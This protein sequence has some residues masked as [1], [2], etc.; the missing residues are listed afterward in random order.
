MKS[1]LTLPILFISMLF[2]ASCEKKVPQSKYDDL[3]YEYEDLKS[4]YEDLQSKYEDLQD[5][6][7]DCQRALKKCKDDLF[8]SDF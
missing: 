6:L 7:Y 4:E 2:F 8:W 1:K 5:E 3:Y